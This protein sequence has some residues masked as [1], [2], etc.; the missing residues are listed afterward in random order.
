MPIML[1]LI[2][3]A[4]II[5]II[6]FTARFFLINLYYFI[7][8]FQQKEFKNAF[9]D[10]I[11]KI[12]LAGVLFL[13]ILGIVAGVNAFDIIISLVIWACFITLIYWCFTFIA[14]KY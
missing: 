3:I 1:T 12:L 5:V 10:N 6:A 14:K 4:I 7:T 9:I 8:D 13:L 2:I 11:Y